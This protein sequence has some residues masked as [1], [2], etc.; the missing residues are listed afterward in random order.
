MSASRREAN[1]ELVRRCWRDLYARDFDAVGA[2][3]AEDGLYQDVPAPDA[4]AVGPRAVALRLRIGL[5]TIERYEHHLHRM[6]ADDEV[7]MTEHTED[8]HWGSGES[9]SLP[10]VSV[11]RIRHGKIALWRDYWDM[12]TLMGAAPRWWVEQILR[13]AA[14]HGLSSSSASISTSR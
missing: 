1:L 8:W 5:E 13:E 7:V 2:Y 6:V 9:V 14:A 12:D 4:G 11:H 10:F 3:F